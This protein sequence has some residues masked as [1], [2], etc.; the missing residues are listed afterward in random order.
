MSAR[1]YIGVPNK[2]ASE[3]YTFRLPNSSQSIAVANLMVAIGTSQWLEF[4]AQ[5]K[6]YVKNLLVGLTYYM[7]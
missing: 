6:L 1:S 5:N 4:F 3:I 7:F 2:V